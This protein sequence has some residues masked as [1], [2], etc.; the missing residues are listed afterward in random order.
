MEIL[1]ALWNAFGRFLALIGRG[2]IHFFN[3]M[4]GVYTH[5]EPI[6]TD[7]AHRRLLWW[8]IKVGIFTLVCIGLGIFLFTF[9]GG[10]MAGVK[11]LF[12]VV[13]YINIAF[14]GLSIMIKGTKPKPRNNHGGGGHH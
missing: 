3:F 12:T 5:V 10:F 14:A 11:Y 8:R 1:N 6:F 2:A 4:S 9:P 13:V 7:A